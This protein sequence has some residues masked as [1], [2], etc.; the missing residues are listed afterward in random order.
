[1]RAVAPMYLNEEVIGFRSAFMGALPQWLP[2]IWL[3]LIWAVCSFLAYLVV[4]FVGIIVGLVFGLL[5]YVTKAFGIV[6]AVLA[7]L[8]AAAAI[9]AVVAIGV[10]AF[11]VSYVTQVVENPGVIRS[12]VVALSRVA[13]PPRGAR[14]F[15]VW[16]SV[17]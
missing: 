4:V 1:M 5:I 16:R 10:V 11:Y 2:L 15:S 14:C 13:G 8:A 9:I 7:G 3:T 17:R 12:F 6:L